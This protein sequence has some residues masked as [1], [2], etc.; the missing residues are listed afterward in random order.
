[1]NVPAA[2]VSAGALIA[3]AIAVTSHWS[4]TGNGAGVV[5]PDRWTGAV[6]WCATAAFDGP[7]LNCTEKRI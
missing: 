7:A 3:A 6:V 1:M 4:V 5:C 2:I